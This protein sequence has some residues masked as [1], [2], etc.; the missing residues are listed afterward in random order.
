MISF[1]KVAHLKMLNVILKE[2]M[3]MLYAGAEMFVWAVDKYRQ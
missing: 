3:F 1:F 2:E